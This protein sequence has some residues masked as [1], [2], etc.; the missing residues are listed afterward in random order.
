MKRHIS[1]NVTTFVNGSEHTAVVA[2]DR[3]P[4]NKELKL[5]IRSAGETIVLP[6]ESVDEIVAT[7]SF[8]ES[9]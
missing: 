7:L 4:D 8:M 3:D 6:K 5:S 1:L 9:K 2:F